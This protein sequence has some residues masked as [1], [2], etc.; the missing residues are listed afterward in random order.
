MVTFSYL[1]MWFFA[2]VFA[3][4]FGVF[5]HWV[6]ANFQ[7]YPDKLFDGGGASDWALN[8]MMS[9]KYRAWGEYDEAG[10]WEFDSWRNLATH[11]VPPMLLVLLTGILNWSDRADA[12]TYVCERAAAFGLLTRVC[13]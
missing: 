5:S 7:P 12:V 8:E 10:W 4:L 6:H 3:F 11:V 2:F 13:G 9:P 1:V